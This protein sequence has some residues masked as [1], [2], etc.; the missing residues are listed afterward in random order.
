MGRFLE[1]L[2]LSQYRNNLILK[3]GMLISAMIG[4][5]NR[6]TLDMDATLKEAFANTS[7]KRGSIRLLPDVDLILKEIA[8]SA[9]LLDHWR[10]YQRKYDYAAN[11]L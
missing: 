1:R 2:S 3:G 5:D 4:L 8:E 7:E 9:V 10:N 11:V 6:A